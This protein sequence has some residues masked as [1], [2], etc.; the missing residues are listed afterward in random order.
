MAPARALIYGM[1]EDTDNV[2]KRERYIMNLSTKN[3]I[4]SDIAR[5]PKFYSLIRGLYSIWRKAM[6]LLRK[7]MS[8][9]MLV[10]PVNRTK[11]VITSHYGKG[12]GDNAKY[13]VEELVRRHNKYD[14]VWLLNKELYG[15]VCFPDYIRTVKYG[16]LRALFELATA[17]IWIDN[18]RKEF[19]PIKRKSQFYIQTWHGA[20]ASRK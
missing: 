16:S 12:Y 14:I 4:K 19:Y 8:I 5:Y 7:I 3:Q 10:F 9:L 11:V 13:I 6:H 17:K 18:C 15:S 1:D 20:W 2:S